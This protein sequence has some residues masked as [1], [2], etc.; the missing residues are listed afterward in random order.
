MPENTSLPD[1]DDFAAYLAGLVSV[2][3]G[4]R[5]DAYQSAVTEA[6]AVIKYAGRVRKAA[7]EAGF[8]P[9][10]AEAM[11]TDFWTVASGLGDE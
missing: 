11:A 8:S 6:V 2:N 5:D 4:L 1:P 9:E 3:D 7:I 10:T